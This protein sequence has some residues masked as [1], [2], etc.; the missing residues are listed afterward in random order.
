MG[1]LR[2]I[3]FPTFLTVTPSVNI[4]HDVTIHKGF[5]KQLLPLLCVYSNIFYIFL[6]YV[7]NKKILIAIH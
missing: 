1:N 4:F 6:P 7:V 2:H 3:F 5:T